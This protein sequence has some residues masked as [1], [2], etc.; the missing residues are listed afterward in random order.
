VTATDKELLP[1]VPLRTL[2]PLPGSVQP[3]EIGR[4]ASLQAIRAAQQDDSLVLL[5]PEKRPA[6]GDPSTAD[7]FEV[8]V[9]AE[10]V[11]VIQHSPS[12]L[13]AVMRTDERMRIAD[14]VEGMSYLVARVEPFTSVVDD[15]DADETEIEALVVKVLEALTPVLA[16]QARL[17]GDGGDSPEV[18]DI[19][20]ADDLVHL[21]TQHM[22]LTR[23]QLLELL[24]EP[25]PAQRLR[26][27]LPAIERMRDVIKVGTDIRNELEGDT[28][29]E[30]REHVLRERMRAIQKELGEEGE[31]EEID[32][33]ADRI[34]ASKMP[35]EVREVAMREVGRMRHMQQG[36]PQWSVSQTYVEWLLDIPWGRISEDTLDVPAA[37]A[38][39]D[40]EH[41]GLEKVKK[42][43]LEFIAV[44]K[45]APDKHGPILCLVGPPGV[46]KTSLGRSIA[47]SLGREYVRAALG[48][49]R[50][51]SEIRGHRRTY[52]GALPGRI[53]SSLKKAKTMNPVFVLDEVDKLGSDHRG[54]PTS[55][56]LEVLDP[57]QNC[58]FVD[59]YLEVP[60]DLSRVM[61]VATANQLETIPLA[62]LDRMEIIHVPS[63]TREEKRTIARLHLLPKQMAE[64]GLAAGTITMNDEALDLVIAGYTREAGVRNVER[65]LGALCRAVAVD[66]ASGRIDKL[67]ISAADIEKLLGPRRHHDD[68]AGREPEVGVVTGMAWTPTGGDILFVE[69]REMPGTGQLKLT[70]QVGDVMREST[71]TALSW[72]RA[73]ADKFGIDRERFQ[74]S[75][76]HI[77][78]PAG[79]IRKDGPSAGVA[80][81][82]VLVSLY[83]NRPVRHD[84]AITGEVTLRGKVLPVGGIKEKLLAAH[85]AGIKTIVL[86]ARNEKDLVDIPAEIKDDLE[87]VL[88][89]KV[90]EALEVALGEALPMP[91]DD[92]S[93]PPVEP[94]GDQRDPAP[95]YT[96][97]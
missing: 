93:A 15:D 48:G 61:F 53:V 77:H 23:E 38:I 96:S 55:A 42:R 72:L 51:E 87:I 32:E 47:H 9:L 83:S 54:D 74:R 52:I 1:V 79:A 19:D 22:E 20:D 41:S 27:I 64:H 65:E 44:R 85:R 49:V 7:L 43:I 66:I 81:T 73:N 76:L 88:V 97:N 91:D 75:D 2:V 71:L 80:I 35:T 13:T 25:A 39:L 24:A 63:Y 46:G 40:A 59:H 62:L 4:G 14:F 28:T 11:Q 21:A 89:N 90:E 3:V 70:G 6:S 45:L 68:A 37:R 84:V 67:E 36:A 18:V 56:L 12:H 94:S 34:R 29:R 31:D 33:L 86:P 26:L 69:V 17:E 10:I 95:S 58:E 57:E 92:R 60:V 50:D 30:A 82:T 8:G 78:L 16:E 5:V